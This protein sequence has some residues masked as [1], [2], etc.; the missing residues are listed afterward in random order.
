MRRAN[1]ATESQR[2]GR[3]WRAGRLDRASRELSSGALLLGSALVLLTLFA[4]PP[5]AAAQTTERED[6]PPLTPTQQ[7]RLRIG[8]DALQGEPPADPTGETEVDPETGE[9]VAIPTHP[10]IPSG[11]AAAAVV[12]TNLAI[13]R[14]MLAVD[15][16]AF[17]AA[18]E[19]L[20]AAR[21][22]VVALGR[23]MGN[24]LERSDRGTTVG[25]LERVRTQLGEAQAMARAADERVSTLTEALRGRV[26][27]I[28]VLAGELDVLGGAEVA[29]ADPI[30]GRWRVEIDGEGVAGIFNL[31]LDGARIRGVYL[32][33]DGRSGSLEGSFVGPQLRLER[34]DRDR[35]FDALFRGTLARGGG[36]IE[37]FWEPTILSRGGPGG[38]SWSAARLSTRTDSTDL[39]DDLEA[40]EPP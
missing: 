24:L 19:D 31:E 40:T 35:G 2:D 1:D 9:T 32:L 26:M 29:Q 10:R 37:G 38:D 11:P 3:G 21:D 14:R 28:A 25:E 18:L 7:Q 8:P 17:E 30:S 23:R 34:R 36:R 16:A 20:E 27:H 12:S 5:P 13:E 22:G 39:E 4:A 15:R 6:P 33:E